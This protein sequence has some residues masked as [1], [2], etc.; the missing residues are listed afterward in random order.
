MALRLVRLPLVLAVLAVAGATL[1]AA[2]ERPSPA[3]ADVA[4]GTH[5]R[6]VFD[7][8]LPA[9]SAARPAPVL[10]YFHG[11][12]FTSGDKRQVPDALLRGA[13][14]AGFAVVSVNYRLFPEVTFPAPH[15]DAARA[16]QTVRARAKEWGIDPER[17]ALG[18]SSAGAGLAL[19]L[20]FH[21]DLAETASDDPV[22]RQSTRVRCAVV[23]GAQPTYDPA[24]IRELAGESAARHPLFERMFTAVDA[25]DAPAVR[26]L[27]LAASPLTYLTHDDPPVFAYYSEPWADVPPGSRAG[28]GIHHPKLGRHLQEK[29]TQLGLRC[30][31]HHKDNDGPALPAQLAFLQTH[32][33]PSAPATPTRQP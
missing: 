27:F 31:L 16:V 5:A 19:W 28:Q 24:A 15:Q 11:G 33:F 29:M 4:Y 10:I 32:L 2:A 6:Q 8:W 22:A 20:A 17:V 25:A 9:A 13:Q 23:S 21:D 18:G 30:V 26:A 14:S 7:L 3:Q 12:G 1:H